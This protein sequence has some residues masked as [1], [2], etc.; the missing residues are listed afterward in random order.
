LSFL[1]FFSANVVV[2][3]PPA[4]AVLPVA[5]PFHRPFGDD[6]ER[7]TSNDDHHTDLYKPV[8]F[9]SIGLFSTSKKIASCTSM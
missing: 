3:L 4:F 5:D 6:D 2:D 1:F 8:C 7:A 9:F